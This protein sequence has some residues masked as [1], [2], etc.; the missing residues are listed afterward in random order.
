ME[1]KSYPAPKKEWVMT[2]EEFS[3]FLAW[4]NP[5]R[6]LAADMYETIRRRLIKFF[7]CR[8]CAVSEE[9]ADETINR[10]I[11]KIQEIGDSYVGE[12]IPYFIAVARNV[13]L[14]NLRKQPPLQPPTT[15]SSFATDEE[16]D[17]LDGCMERFTPRTR[18]LV[19]SYF[20]ED[21]HDKIVH[22]KKLAEELGVPLNALR[23]KVCRI[24]AK[25]QTCVF[26][27]LRMKA[28]M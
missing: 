10:V 14:E 8:G 2:E 15:E 23:I 3:K 28:E 16:L 20:Q 1:M 21:K 11:R 9:L 24:R 5:N 27:C 17:C 19:I 26:D 6:N 4:L 25:L 18:D 12:R 22:R 13:Y 7:I